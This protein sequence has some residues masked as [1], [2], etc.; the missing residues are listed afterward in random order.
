MVNDQVHFFFGSSPH[1]SHLSSML[2]R[3]GPI[4]DTNSTVPQLL[5][6]EGQCRG[7]V[8]PSNFV[9]FGQDPVKGPTRLDQDLGGS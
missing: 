8:R 5:M 3:L 9:T 7:F 6:V 2:S 1:E 4:D